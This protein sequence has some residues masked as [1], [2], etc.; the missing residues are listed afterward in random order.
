MSDLATTI[1]THLAGYCE[2]DPARR[3]E[4]LGSVWSP[5]GRL[6]SI[7]GFFGDLVPKA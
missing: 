6:R 7:L 1:D 3:A 4:L 2:P 5:P